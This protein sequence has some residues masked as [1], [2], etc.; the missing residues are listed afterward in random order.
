MVDV[1]LHLMGT[2][3]PESPAG[4]GAERGRIVQR[5]AV[6]GAV[7]AVAIMV[8]VALVVLPRGATAVR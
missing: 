7:V 2:P 5:V 8:T 6:G 4:A 3:T 1:C